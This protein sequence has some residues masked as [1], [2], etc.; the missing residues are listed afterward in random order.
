MSTLYPLD[1]YSNTT[2]NRALRAIARSYGERPQDFVQRLHR[3]DTKALA[4]LT[5]LAGK[6][7][8]RRGTGFTRAARMRGARAF[9]AATHLTVKSHVFDELLTTFGP[10]RAAPSAPRRSMALTSSERA[11]DRQIGMLAYLG[12]P[13]TDE[14]GRPLT[15][16]AASFR[17]GH[18]PLQRDHF[19]R[20]LGYGF[21]VI[22]EPWCFGQYSQAVTLAEREGLNVNPDR[23]RF[24]RQHQ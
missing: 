1:G 23:L 4:A 19:E 9:T 22:R 13:T 3:G 18:A 10:L 8:A 2:A 7:H 12:Q 24:L 6:M 21:D 15:K 11:T 5:S 14:R 20:L 16:Q 17:I